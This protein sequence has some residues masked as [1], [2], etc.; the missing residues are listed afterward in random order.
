MRHREIRK[1]VGFTCTLLFWIFLSCLLI[2]ADVLLF[3]EALNKD[4]GACII[5]WVMLGTQILALL[6]IGAS[7]GAN[8]YD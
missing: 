2:W 1:V 5:S 4:S 7:W 8:N 3:R 6:A